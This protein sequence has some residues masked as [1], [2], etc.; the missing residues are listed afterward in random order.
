MTSAIDAAEPAD[1]TTN[2][3]NLGSKVRANFLIAKNEIS[4]LQSGVGAALPLTGGTLAGPG[5][6]FINSATASTNTTTGA[7]RVAGGAGIGGALN[8]G[9]ALTVG[10]GAVGTP[11]VNISDVGLYRVASGTLGISSVGVLSAQFGSTG[12]TSFGATAPTATLEYTGT[13]SAG[14]SIGSFLF[15]GRNDAAAAVSY[16]Q[17]I[18]VSG[19]VT[20]GAQTGEL[21]AYLYIANVLTEATRTDL[22][23]FDI[24]GASKVLKINGT[25]VLSAQ[26]TGWTTA[27]T[28]TAT[29][30]TAAT[31]TAPTVSAGY[32]QAEV[33]AIAD[34]LQAVSRGFKALTDDMR[35]HGAIAA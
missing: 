11:T 28:G 23:G 26:K 14:A 29:R 20:A 8:L 5:D 25:Q 4:A 7:L 30:T 6:L 16:A 18:G 32:V 10:A 12:F 15:R 1:G 24:R 2:F 17:L 35:S 31:Y 21:R 33:Q 13:A 22:T 34:A 27:W 3:G 19:V 9:G